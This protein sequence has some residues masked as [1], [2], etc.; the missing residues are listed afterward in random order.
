MES[1]FSPDYAVGCGIDLRSLFLARPETELEALDIARDLIQQGSVGVIVLDL[2]SVLPDIHV[3]RRFAAILARSG[4]VVLLLVALADGANPRAVLSGTPAGL[5]LFIER[6]TW[7]T[8]Q[9]DIRGYRTCITV[10][11][12]HKAAGRQVTIDIDFDVG[13]VGDIP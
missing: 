9:M 11:G 2:G 12:R 5:R 10:L 1:T 6:E 4:C 7:L 3:L 13:F 8:R